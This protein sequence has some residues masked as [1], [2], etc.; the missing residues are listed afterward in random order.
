MSDSDTLPE[1]YLKRTI[2]GYASNEICI[3]VRGNSLE[4]CRK[5]FNEIYSD[6][7]DEIEKQTMGKKHE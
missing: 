1:I 4:E 3:Q 6:T 5:H 2:G 7:L